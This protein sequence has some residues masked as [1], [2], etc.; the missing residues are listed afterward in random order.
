MTVK[1]PNDAITTTMTSPS[2]C[3]QATIQADG[4]FVI[5]GSTGS[6]QVQPKN[7]ELAPQVRACS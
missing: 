2:G 5:S 4:D 3:T 7:D 6:N 1:Q